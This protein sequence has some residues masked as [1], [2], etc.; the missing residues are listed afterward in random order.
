MKYM[1]GR[2]VTC[3]VLYFH[4]SDYRLRRLLK[5]TVSTLTK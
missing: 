5:M 4:G 2:T 1:V 3:D